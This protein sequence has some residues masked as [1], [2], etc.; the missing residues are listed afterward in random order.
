MGK[1]VKATV[2]GNSSV[3]KTCMLISYATNSFPTEYVPTVFDNYPTKAVVDGNPVDLILF[4]T[5][6]DA[7]YDSIRPLNYPGTDVFL[8]CFCVTWYDS[9]EG[10]AKK[11]VDEVKSKCPDT[12]I[13]LVGT[14]SDLRNDANE[15]SKLKEQGKAPITPEQGEQLAAVIGAHKYVECSALTQHNLKTVFEEAVKLVL[16]PKPAPKPADKSKCLIQ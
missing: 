11:W 15:I 13:V 1:E 2:V 3:G 9:A 5:A 16:Y 14:K 6:G 4:D 8:V 7:E 10:V 12:P